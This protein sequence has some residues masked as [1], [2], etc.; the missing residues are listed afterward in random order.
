MFQLRAPTGHAMMR[1]DEEGRLAPPVDASR[2]RNPS[3]ARSSFESP[4]WTMNLMRPEM[5][6]RLHEELADRLEATRFAAK[7]RDERSRTS[8]LIRESAHPPARS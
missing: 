6:R 7:A 3:I 5:S 4:T 8:A 1:L 2:P